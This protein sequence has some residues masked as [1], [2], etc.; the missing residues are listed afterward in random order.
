MFGM[1]TLDIGIGLMVVYL[2]L[3]FVC[4]AANEFISGLR[5]M[6]AKNLEKCINNF[7][8]DG[9]KN[10]IR[11][12]FFSHSMIRSLCKDTESKKSI[13]SYISSKTFFLVLM[14]ILDKRANTKG[15]DEPDIG[16]M[17]SSF[18]K[19][20]HLNKI[21]KVLWEESSGN[22]DEFKENLEAWYDNVMSRVVGWYKRDLQILT[23]GV[24]FIIVL[25][26]NAD[27]IQIIKSLSNDPALRQTL[28]T[29]AGML[30]KQEHQLELQQAGM[31]RKDLLSRNAQKLKNV[32]NELKSLGIPLG[33]K[34]DYDLPDN[35]GVLGWILLTVSK[36]IGLAITVFA[37]SLGA[38]FWFDMLNRL[39]N[40]RATGHREQ[41]RAEINA[42]GIKLN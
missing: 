10:E 29:Q 33:W 35:L 40:F 18:A 39:I 3:S 4:T 13:P 34:L 22:I 24:A 12:A 1:Q 15:E 36:V 7:L 23:I 16:E 5:N 2:A 9:K 32:H 6:R 19:Q 25:I 20:T 42:K 11:N 30:V 31:G 17:I 26:S 38:P 21:L 41:T 8:G 27:T 37:V 14:D 28:V